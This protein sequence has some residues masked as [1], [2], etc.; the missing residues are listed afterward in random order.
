MDTDSM[1][2]P[3]VRT[4]DGYVAGV[5]DGLGRYFDVNPTLIRIGWLAAVV[6]FGTGLLAYVA[7]WWL[8]PR[9]DQLALEQTQWQRNSATGRYSPPLQRTT[10]DKKIF[11]VCGGL[12]RSWQIDPVFVR[13]GVLGLAT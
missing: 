12:A 2:G 4:R 7:M 10:H 13:L 1:G 11:G 6:F 8:M 5:C 9:E 3:L